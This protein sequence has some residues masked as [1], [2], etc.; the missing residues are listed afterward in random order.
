MCLAVPA[1]IIE[2]NNKMATVD[3]LG[4]QKQISIAMTP[5]AKVG[6]WVLIH[7]GFAISITTEEMANEIYTLWEEMDRNAANE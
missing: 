2:I 5:E 7:A 1:K 6:D 4:N 3:L